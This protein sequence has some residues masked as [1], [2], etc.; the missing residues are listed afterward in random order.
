MLDIDDAVITVTAEAFKREM[1]RY[2]YTDQRVKMRDYS[3]RVNRPKL[4]QIVPR[5]VASDTQQKASY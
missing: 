4:S 2:L 1:R 3:G 5:R